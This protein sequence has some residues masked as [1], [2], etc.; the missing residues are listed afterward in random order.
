MFLRLSLRGLILANTS[1]FGMAGIAR[2]SDCLMMAGIEETSYDG[3]LSPWM[4]CSIA[5]TASKLFQREGPHC[6]PIG[7]ATMWLLGVNEF[8][9]YPG[10]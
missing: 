1:F 9:W 7:T 8:Q 2:C 5:T 3:H 10:A 4:P 6:Q